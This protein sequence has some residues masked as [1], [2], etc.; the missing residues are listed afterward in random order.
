MNT[1]GMVYKPREYFPSIK[2]NNECRLLQIFIRGKIKEIECNLG[3]SVVANGFGLI[4][5]QN[6]DINRIQ[7][8]NINTNFFVIGGVGRATK[9]GFVQSSS[10]GCVPVICCDNICRI[11]MTRRRS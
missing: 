11:C 1:T 4:L 2:T 9:T 7:S 8:G 10:G 3:A 6:S 5:L